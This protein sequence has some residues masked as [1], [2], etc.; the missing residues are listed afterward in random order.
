MGTTIARCTGV[1]LLLAAVPGVAVAQTSASYSLTEHTF[2]MGGRPADGA[3][4]SSASFQIS[5]DALG[6]ALIRSGLSSASFSMDGGL[7]PALA[8]PGEAMHL[9]FADR[10][11][12]E[13]DAHAAAT[14]YHLYRDSLDTLSDVHAGTCE[15]QD[16]PA[17]TTVDSA[18]PT[19][20]V[21]WFYLVT[22]ENR[23]GQE[24]TRGANDAGVER[25]DTGVCP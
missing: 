17:S 21:A 11:T 6:E 1:A 13:W 3:T 19:Q 20:G 22:V 12:L 2:N 25:A 23:L 18:N 7:L 14:V 24:G 4:A 9:I 15:Q 8:P 5:L 16:L 10:E